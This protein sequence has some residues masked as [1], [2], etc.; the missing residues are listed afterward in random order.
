[1]TTLTLEQKFS[2]TVVKTPPNGRLDGPPTFQAAPDG[3][4]RLEAA[5]D[6]LSATVFAASAGNVNVTCT[7]LANG[8]PL[9]ATEEVTVSEPFA[10]SIALVAGAPEAQ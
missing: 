10:T 9:T 7:A 1:M 6:G 2:L 5:A 8:L 3:I 4:V